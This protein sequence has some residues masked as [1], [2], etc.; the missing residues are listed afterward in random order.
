[1]K[2]RD[3]ANKNSISYQTAWTHFKAGLIPNSRQLPTGT[4]VIDENPIVNTPSKIALYARVSPSENKTDLDSQLERLRQYA[5]AKGYQIDKEVKEIASGLNDQRPKLISLL[6]DQEIGLIIVEHKDRLT[7][8]GFNYI[9]QL[10]SIQNRKIEVINLV[11]D[12]KDRILE[13]L[14]SIITSF[15]AKIYG[16]RRNK[17]KT[18]K[19]IEELLN[20]N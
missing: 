18:Q 14:V 4:I 12:D 1:M 6:K 16:Q 7:R 13:D 3:W 5:T 2:L 17:R 10:L 20:D 8:F 11:A 15:T 19:I 9:E